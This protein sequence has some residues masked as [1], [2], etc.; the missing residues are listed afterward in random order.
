MSVRFGKG[1]VFDNCG[2]QKLALGFYSQE[3][4]ASRLGE[5]VSNGS[6]RQGYS[7]F[8]RGGMETTNDT[9]RSFRGLRNPKTG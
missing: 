6:E 1:E 9:P 2:V 5:I 4:S 7:K 8:V 3:P